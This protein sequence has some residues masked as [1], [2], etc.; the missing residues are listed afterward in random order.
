MPLKS[1]VPFWGLLALAAAPAMAQTP[2]VEAFPSSLDESGLRAWLA[3][4]T[5]MPPTAVVSIGSNSVI[6]LRSVVGDPAGPG[7]F[8]IQ[9]RAEVVNQRTA[10]QGGYLSWSADLAIDCVQRRTRAMGITNYTQRNLKGE[11]RVVGGPAADWVTPAVGTQLYSLLSSVCDYSF[12]R[13]LDQQ[14][15][16]AT[17]ASP[18]AVAAQAPPP[19]PAPPAAP[20]QTAQAAPRPAPVAAAPPPPVRPQPAPAPPA[21]VRAAQAAP[22]PAAPIQTVQPPP[23]VRPTPA[24]PPPA[25]VQTAQVAPAPVAPVRTAQAMPLQTPVS[26]PTPFTPPSMMPRAEPP[27]MQV[28]VSA[29]PGQAGE[30]SPATAAPTFAPPPPEPTPAAAPPP[31]R[32]TSKAAIQVGAS[33]SESD[34]RGLA[35]KA[36]RLAPGGSALSTSIAKV[37][38]NGKTVYRALLYG[39]TGKGEAASTCQAIKARG[40]DCF[41]RDS[42]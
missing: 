29:P 16:A 21:P 8:Q 28:A 17:P 32:A 20:V 30:P 15:A 33:D 13:P 6:G 4:Q 23:P 2:P 39:F 1:S 35:A 24:P 41:P 27:K 25:P 18:P 7:R 42:Y 40:Q 3:A 38:V 19:R 14:T 10:A 12:K 22:P 26:E 36:K 31:R 37:N 9:I 11:G 5:D 34:A